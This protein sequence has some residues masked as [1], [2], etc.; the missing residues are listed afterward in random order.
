VNPVFDPTAE[1]PDVVSQSA[2]DSAAV[3]IAAI[4]PGPT[5]LQ[6]LSTAMSITGVRLE[7]RSDTTDALVGISI[8]TK[9]TPLAGTIAPKMPPQSAAVFSLRTNTPGGTGRG[10]VFWPALGHTLGTNTRLSVSIVAA[11]LTEFQAYT[12]SIRGAL[13][14]AFPLVGFD[15]AVRSKTS[16]ATPHVV[17]VQLGDAVD[18]Q[19]RRRDNLIEAY[20]QVTIP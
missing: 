13:A 8:A 14:T 16:H 15:L 9:A 1:L 4:A 18:T 20:Q 17:R 7:V 12:G 2:L 6:G 11:L 5:M 10:R 3:A 19:R